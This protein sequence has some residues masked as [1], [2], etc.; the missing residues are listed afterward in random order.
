MTLLECRVEMTVMCGH[1]LEASAVGAGE[2]SQSY[3]G[4]RCRRGTGDM[5]IDWVSPTGGR[6]GR[7]FFQGRPHWPCAAGRGRA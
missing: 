7:S 1:L 6:R 3:L 5:M 4:P 2:G